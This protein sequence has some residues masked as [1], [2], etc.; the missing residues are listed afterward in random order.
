MLRFSISNAFR[1]KTITF[2]AILGAALGAGLMT[3]L[4]SLSGGMDAK[5][6]STLDKVAGDILVSSK[7]AS[8]IGGFIG[9]GTPIPEK[10]VTEIKQMDGVKNTQPIISTVIPTQS[11]KSMIPI[12]TPFQGV[13]LK[14]NKE[15]DGALAKITEGLGIENP[16]EVVVGKSVIA[17]TENAGGSLKIGD[18]IIVP[19]ISTTSQ[20]SLA[21]VQAAGKIPV[22][23]FK[24]VGI[25]ETGNEIN[26]RGVV[27]NIDD[28]R[29]VTGI[30]KDMV[31]TI[32]VTANSSNDLERVANEINDKYKDSATPIQT[33]VSKDL[34]GD[35]NKTMDIFRNFLLVISAVAAIAGGVS[36]MIIMLMSVT[37]RMQ[38]FGILK[39]AGWS[40]KNILTSVF[41]ESLTLAIIGSLVGLG[42]GFVLGKFIDSQLGEHIS[43]LSPDLAIKIILFG[44]VMGV[45]GGIYPAW[46]AARV[47]PI[48]TLKSA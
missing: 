13:N 4:L 3:V 47:S 37:E 18:T 36:I 22:K 35:I 32:R 48:E 8:V 30:P 21:Q 34:L 43:L 11:L 26:D 27:G 31:N 33:T 14:Q 1:R 29:V 41:V 2:L 24:V 7:A 28:V 17:Q 5:L 10:M 9:G 42:F 25:F 46:R 6:N 44:I 39:A 15:S 16:Y 12:G 45:L 19:I 23:E 38:E 20:A 40:N